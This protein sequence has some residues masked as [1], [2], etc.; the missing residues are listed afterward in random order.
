MAEANPVTGEV[1]SLHYALSEGS[2][3]ATTQERLA[4]ALR[5]QLPKAAW[6][7]RWVCGEVGPGLNG[8]R[9]VR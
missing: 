7:R 5:K 3:L 4:E 8:K 1:V 2:E 6:P 9:R